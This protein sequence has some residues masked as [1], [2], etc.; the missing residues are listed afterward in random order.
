MAPAT[1]ATPT[2]NT[3]VPAAN[4]KPKNRTSKRITMNSVQSPRR[5]TGAPVE[6]FSAPRSSLAGAGLYH[7]PPQ[8]EQRRFLRVP[9]RLDVYKASAV[10][11]LGP[12]QWPPVAPLVSVSR[13]CQPLGEE[14]VDRVRHRSDRAGTPVVRLQMLE[15]IL[16]G[17]VA[18]LD[19]DRRY[20]RRLEH[21]EAGRLERV[22]VHSRDRLHLPHQ[23]P[24]ETVGKG[25]GFALGKI[26]QDVGNLGGFFGQVDA[27]DG[28]S[29]VFGLRELFGL[30][31]RG[32]VGQGVDRSALRV[33]FMTRQRSEERRV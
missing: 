5:M 20:I 1:A 7:T 27:A 6:V 17:D 3:T 22:L 8:G 26:D 4:K 33:A 31:V 10:A 16:V 15:I 30:R 28:V 24:R 11:K 32:T 18:E 9:R 12:H 2:R 14:R 23:Q 29:P 25:A 19:Q 21:P 13:G